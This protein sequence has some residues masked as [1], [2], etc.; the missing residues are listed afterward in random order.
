MRLLRRDP[1]LYDTVAHSQRQGVV[2]VA[3]SGRV[4]VLGQGVAQVPVEVA[5]QAGRRHPDAV[6]RIA[7]RLLLRGRNHETV[8]QTLPGGPAAPLV[9]AATARQPHGTGWER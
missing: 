3:V 9:A 8:S 2:T 1:A 6:L 5:L 7:A 4:A